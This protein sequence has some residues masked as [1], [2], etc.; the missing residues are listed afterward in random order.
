M[1]AEVQ[2]DLDRLVECVPAQAPGVAVGVYRDGELVASACSGLASIEHGVPISDDT[3]FDLGS[4]SKQMTAAAVVLLAHDGLLD[5]DAD[6]HALVPELP[7]SPPIS[8]RQ[9]LAHTTGLRDYMAMIDIVGESFASIGTEADFLQYL[10]RAG[11]NFA[12]GTAISNS[13]TGYVLAGLAVRRATGRSIAQVLRERVFEPLGMAHTV[14]RDEVGQVVA[15]LALSYAPRP[16]R[17]HVR[18]EMPEALLGDKA[19][20][21]SL[22]DLAPWHGFLA[23]GR[24]LGT[25]VRD[26]LLRRATLADGRALPY[27]LGL[28]HTPGA[29]R[30]LLM[31]RGGVWGYRTFLI[32]DPQSGCGVTVL[33][34]ATDAPTR[35]LAW[36]AMDLMGVRPAPIRKYDKEC[37]GVAG[38][39][40]APEITE[41]LAVHAFGAGRIEADIGSATM[42][43][44]AVAADRWVHEHPHNSPTLELVGTTLV[45]EDHMGRRVEYTRAARAE[46]PDP[47]RLTGTY[48]SDE[49]DA[50]IV[51]VHDGQTLWYQC[52]RHEPRPLRYAADWGG[53]PI[54]HTG[55]TWLRFHDRGLSLNVGHT[56]LP[57][58][59]ERM[60]VC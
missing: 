10:K 47:T 44:T 48:H 30:T 12:P 1:G 16:G 36:A 24:V 23:D 9:A 14:M 59:G 42:A 45:W 52:G 31:H 17:G 7:E 37:A 28:F 5:L 4:I 51:I 34:N 43:F 29:D 11:L 56:H 46:E 55:G 38:L 8:L 35:Q 54:Y 27:S 20:L 53:D 49:L 33:A 57:T 25:A 58:V 39:W 15:H 6:L 41:C 18:V 13:S 22:R 32:A 50:G 40:F 19:V 26:E 21:T 3:A 60:I 2:A